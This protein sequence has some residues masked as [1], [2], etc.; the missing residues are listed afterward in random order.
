M[1]AIDNGKPLGQASLE[2]YA[3]VSRGL[4]AWANLSGKAEDYELARTVVRQA[5]S[6]FYGKH[7]WNLSEP[8]FIPMESPVDVMTDG[9]TP[10]PSA[11]VIAV[12]LR[13][14]A[15]L[16]DKGLLHQALSAANSGQ[17]LV[18]SDPFW[19]V[20]QIQAIGISSHQSN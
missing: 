15:R 9:P 10:S 17:Q 19:Y 2:D 14:A 8:G 18:S 16:N 5:W 3:Y 4:L 12:S 1:R 13:L 11:T 20:S 7:G 6:R